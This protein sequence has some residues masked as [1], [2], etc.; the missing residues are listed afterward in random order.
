MDL[1][2]LNKLGGNKYSLQTLQKQ[3]VQGMRSVV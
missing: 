1:A 3:Q 2:M